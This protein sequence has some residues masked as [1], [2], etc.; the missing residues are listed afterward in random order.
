MMRFAAHPHPT[1]P[2][3][4]EGR[5]HSFGSIPSQPPANPSPF[6]GEAGWGWSPAHDQAPGIGEAK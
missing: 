4:G 5:L 3:K 1:S 6:E 2:S